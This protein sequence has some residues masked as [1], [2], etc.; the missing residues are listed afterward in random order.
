M[1]SRTIS[2]L[3]RMGDFETPAVRSLHEE[4][5]LGGPADVAVL[6]H[7][8]EAIDADRFLGRDAEAAVGFESIERSF[9]GIIES[10]SMVGSPDDLSARQF[11]YH[12]RIVSRMSLLESS[13]GSQIFQD[14]DVVDIVKAV[15]LQHG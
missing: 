5:R 7:L 3:F 10:V 9:S 13:F 1:S 2:A 8:S 4:H 6:I 11:A 15:L 14:L 12:V